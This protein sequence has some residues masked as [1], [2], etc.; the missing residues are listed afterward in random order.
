MLKCLHVHVMDKYMYNLLISHSSGIFFLSTDSVLVYFQFLCQKIMK[1][2][3]ILKYSNIG[4]VLFQIWYCQAFLVR[5]YVTYTVLLFTSKRGQLVIQLD[6]KAH[7]ITGLKF[8]KLLCKLS[9]FITT[10]D[11]AGLENS[12]WISFVCI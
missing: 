4:D 5:S 6:M 11:K 2:K 1:G 10:Q 8:G 9:H 12:T 3:C 7:V